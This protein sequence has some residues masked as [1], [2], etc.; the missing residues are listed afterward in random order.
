MPHPAKSFTWQMRTSAFDEAGHIETPW[1]EHV[2]LI[3]LITPKLLQQYLNL[4]TR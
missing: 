4:L 3:E 2:G 1:Y